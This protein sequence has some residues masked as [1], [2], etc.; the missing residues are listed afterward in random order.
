MLSICIA[1]QW[2][3]WMILTWNCYQLTASIPKH[4]KTKE[5]Y[6]KAKNLDAR[7]E[8][9]QSNSILN[10]ALAAYKDLLTNH[11]QNL[12]DSIFKEV[13]ERCIERMR[14]VGKLKAAVDIHQLLIER[15]DNDPNYRNQLAVSYLLGNQ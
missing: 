10:E 4:P 12:N 3:Y 2:I 5:L 14:F 8:K 11:N 9:Q 7:A 15:F 1:F 6:E 13:G